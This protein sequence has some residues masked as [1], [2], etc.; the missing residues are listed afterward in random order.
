MKACRNT[1]VVGRRRAVFYTASALSRRHARWCNPPQKPASLGLNLG[2]S[3]AW[4]LRRSQC[5]V[6]HVPYARP[7]MSEFEK[8]VP[9]KRDRGFESLYRRV[10]C[11]PDFLFLARRHLIEALAPE[12]CNL[13]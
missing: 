2:G 7:L 12:S 4:S 10:Q 3:R 9:L 6:V 13:D 1:F 5:F 11:E 8:R